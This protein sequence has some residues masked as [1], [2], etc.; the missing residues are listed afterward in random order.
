MSSC[1]AGNEPEL[2]KIAAGGWQQSKEM[3][4]KVGERKKRH[5]EIPVLG[6][7]AGIQVHKENL[8][9]PIPPLHSLLGGAIHNLTVMGFSFIG[10]RGS[11]QA[12]GSL[13]KPQKRAWASEVFRPKLFRKGFFWSVYLSLE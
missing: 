9:L 10:F 6:E 7:T 4:E 11:R 12:L 13:L 3:R 8:R 1:P 5:K 2:C